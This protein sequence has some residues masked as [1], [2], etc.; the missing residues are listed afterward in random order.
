MVFVTHSVDEAIFLSDRVIMFGTH[1]GQII[2]DLTIDLP[3][4]RWQD[5]AAIKSSPKF[6]EFRT[7][8]WGM[9]KQ[10]LDKAT[11]GGKTL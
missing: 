11:S 10:Q 5:E 2:S 4:P 1:P 8:I 7:T 6:V 3:R 9:L